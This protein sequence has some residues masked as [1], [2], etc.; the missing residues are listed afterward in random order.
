MSKKQNLHFLR[1]KIFS[2]P[3]CGLSYSLYALVCGSFLSCSQAT[4]L[5][6]TDTVEVIKQTHKRGYDPDLLK[7]VEGHLCLFS[8]ALE[9][10]K[11]VLE[12]NLAKELAIGVND[13][14]KTTSSVDSSQ[15]F[16]SLSEESQSLDPLEILRMELKA[17]GEQIAALAQKLQVLQNVEYIPPLSLKDSE[18]VP[19]STQ[20]KLTEENMEALQ[21]HANLLFSQ[22]MNDNNKKQIMLALAP[23]SIEQ[24]KL[25]VETIQQHTKTLFGSRRYGNKIIDGENRAQI[26]SALAPLSVEQITVLIK[27]KYKL[28]PNMDDGYQGAGVISALAHLSAE[29]IEAFEQART[30]HAIPYS[31]IIAIASLPLEDYPEIAHHARTIGWGNM[32]YFTP[33]S[34]EKLRAFVL[35]IGKYNDK[36]FNKTYMDQEKI[37]RMMSALVPASPEQIA[38][39]AT[40]FPN[41][42]SAQSGN[43]DGILRIS[44][45]KYLSPEQIAIIGTKMDILFERYGTEQSAIKISIDRS[46]K[47]ILALAPLSVEQMNKVIGSLR[48]TMA[49]SEKCYVIKQFKALSIMPPIN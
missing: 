24:I 41:I 32:I 10:A 35:A 45:L 7:R 28:L 38:A 23:L 6:R 31:F 1:N 11:Q 36:F 22:D 37:S 20:K 19:L 8:S 9:N 48:P 18:E 46:V 3:F 13:S 33:L 21:Q 17:Q 40:Y 26:I 15:D 27:H 44:A 25:F 39:I 34:L 14:T 16:V 5:D 47:I 2:L 42:S 12:E 49:F 43:Y 30:E 29:Q 4:D